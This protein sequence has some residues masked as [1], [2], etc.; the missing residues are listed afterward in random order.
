MAAVAELVD[1]QHVAIGTAARRRVHALAQHHMVQANEV[2]TLVLA[3]AHRTAAAVD[4]RRAQHRLARARLVVAVT[5]AQPAQ[6]WA[7]YVEAALLVVVAAVHIDAVVRVAG[8][9]AA[10]VAC[11]DHVL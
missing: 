7:G 8:D 10:Y 6:V 5:A 2:A 3:A 1:G 4:R 9:A 11:T